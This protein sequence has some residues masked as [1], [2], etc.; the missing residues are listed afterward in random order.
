M[1]RDLTKGRVV[2]SM[3]LFA[4]P[5]ILGDLLQQCYRRTLCSPDKKQSKKLVQ[6]V[7]HIKKIVGYS[8]IFNPSHF[9]VVK[10]VTFNIFSL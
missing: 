3:L 8:R 4:I 10:S 7:F 1:S 5:M 9:F 6:H 2:K